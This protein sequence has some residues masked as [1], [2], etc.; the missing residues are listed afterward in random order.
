MSRRKRKTQIEGQF[1]WR[2]VEMLE[3]PPFRALSRAGHRVLD[4]L[5]IELAH[6]GG[7]GNGA[8]KVPYGQFQA[9][10]VDRE[11]VAPAIREVVAM[12][13]VEITKQGRGGNAEYRELTE[14]R[15]TYK[16][17]DFANPTNEWRSVGADAD[18]VAAAARKAKNPDAVARSKRS[19][20]KQIFGAAFPHVSGRKTRPENDPSPGRE[21][22]RSTPGRKSRPT[23]YI[24]GE[25]T[26]QPPRDA[27][28][29]HGAVASG[30][31]ATIA[32]LAAR[33]RDDILLSRVA[34]RLGAGQAGWLIVQEASESDLEN[35]LALE[36]RGELD[37]ATLAATR[38]KYRRGAA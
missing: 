18:A 28:P 4:R 25:G 3:S 30:A 17:T 34:G 31:A 9:Y 29:S 15:L 13:F 23:I 8:L 37:A 33:D 10:G 38:L 24:S 16:H 21:S 19:A 5:E 12:G 1:T 27:R 35:L 32:P 36:V 6:H 11:S 22:R 2:L 7:T 14:Y 20:G 26:E